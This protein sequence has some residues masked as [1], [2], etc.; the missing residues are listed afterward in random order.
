MSA[1]HLKEL[2]SVSILASLY[3]AHR[4]TISASLFYLLGTI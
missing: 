4:P 3:S 1:T 2:L